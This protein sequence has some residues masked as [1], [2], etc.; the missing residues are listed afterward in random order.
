MNS[1]KHPRLPNETV[2]SSEY[3]EMSREEREKGNSY[4]YLKLSWDCNDT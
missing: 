1:Q 2:L 4:M 3:P